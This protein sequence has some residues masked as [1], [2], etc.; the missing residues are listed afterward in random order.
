MT[1][2]L[3]SSFCLSLGHKFV[4]TDPEEIIAEV[5]RF[6]TVAP[7]PAIPFAHQTGISL[8]GRIAKSS[9]IKESILGGIEVDLK[10]ELARV[11]PQAEGITVN[12]TS[13]TIKQVYFII[14][15]SPAVILKGISYGVPKTIVST[16]G[17][18]VLLNDNVNPLKWVYEQQGSN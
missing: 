4:L 11:F 15:I 8:S 12:V 9:Q 3:P 18:L 1:T 6:Y 16:N 14:S 10:Y 2:P 7:D 13:Q 5:I 17:T